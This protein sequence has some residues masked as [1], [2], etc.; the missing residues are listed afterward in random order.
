MRSSFDNE[1]VECG[2]HYQKSTI[3]A[4]EQSCADA[5][6]IVIVSCGKG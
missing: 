3:A 6:Q 4:L 5:A 1:V 2:P